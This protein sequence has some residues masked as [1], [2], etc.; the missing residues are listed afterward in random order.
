ML[1]TKKYHDRFLLDPD[2][3][4]G[5]YTMHILILI[6]VMITIN[7][8]FAASEMALVSIK[9]MDVHKLKSQ[10]K[11]NASLLEKV[12]A[13]S[14]RYL[15]TIQVAITLAGFISSAFAGSQLS[16]NLVTFFASVNITISNS[17]AVVIITFI[18]SFFTL[19]LGELV[20]KRIAITDPVKFSLFC[21]PVIYVFMTAF[22]PFVWL[23]SVSTKGF[24]TL[25]GIKSY[26]DNAMISEKEI[27]E[28]IVYGQV[29]GLYK[30]EEKNMMKRIF[31]LD[32]LT[33]DMIMT[34]KMDVIGLDLANPDIEHVMQSRYSRIPVFNGNMNVIAGVIFLKD[35]LFELRYKALDQIDMES[36]LKPP[37]IIDEDMK[38]NV[39][40]KQMRDTFEHL[41]FITNNENEF[42]GIVTLEDI[43]EEIV[44]NIYDEHDLVSETSETLSEFKY[45]FAGDMLISDIEEKLGI[46][47]S[48][49]KAHRTIAEYVEKKLAES[50]KKRAPS[51]IKINVGSIKVLSRTK[52]GIDRIELKLDQNKVVD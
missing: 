4:R 50:P 24:L 7:A 46:E 27:K 33:V 8:F 51:S 28:M 13:D 32:D 14:T 39:L 29:Q 6:L 20:P 52:Q 41:T 38:I 10:G 5:G 42:L 49:A 45:I 19:V 43:I 16:G 30:S 48:D 47:I 3:K 15:S 2:T 11:K 12:T 9:P 22:K 36:L 34:P 40:L 37:C 1:H 17:L 31:A 25:I 44:G 35:L 26:K 23:L 21:A 18:L